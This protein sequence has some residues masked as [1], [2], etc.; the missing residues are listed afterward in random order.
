MCYC[1]C[2]IKSSFC[3]IIGHI[4]LQQP[5]HPT[6]ASL[7]RL[8]DL[9]CKAYTKLPSIPDIPREIIEPGLVCVARCYNSKW[10][11]VQVCSLIN[12]SLVDGF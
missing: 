12:F 9:M 6:H 5:S 7:S 1:M 3:H 2:L 11:R 4:F 8:E 10:Y